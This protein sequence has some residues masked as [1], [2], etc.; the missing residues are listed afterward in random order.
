[1]ARYSEIVY[2]MVIFQKSV[3]ALTRSSEYVYRFSN[4]IKINR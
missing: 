3:Y 1:M 2:P 4:K